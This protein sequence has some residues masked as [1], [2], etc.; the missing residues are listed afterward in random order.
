MQLP[1][2]VVI[3][4]AMVT[5]AIATSDSVTSDSIIS[6]SGESRIG[7]ITVSTESGKYYHC[8]KITTG[9]PKWEDCLKALEKVK[10]TSA[11]DYPCYNLNGQGSGCKTLET[12]GTCAVNACEPDTWKAFAVDPNA[13]VYGASYLG[14]VCSRD[15]LVQGYFHYDTLALAN[16]G[17]P[18]DKRGGY[19]NIGLSHS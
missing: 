16:A 8:D 17:G 19:V 15:G 7:D 3:M 18:C 10:A 6:D 14:Q 11:K 13:V 4:L 2:V 1:K 9:S 12:V 5:G